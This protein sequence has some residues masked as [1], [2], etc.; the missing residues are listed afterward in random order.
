SLKKIIHPHIIKLK[1]VV[2]ENDTLYLIFEHMECNLYELMR[3]HYDKG[4]KGFPESTVRIV[5]YQVLDGLNY[6]HS[7]G[8]FHR[9]LK[10]ENILCSNLGVIKIGD[11]G[12]AR[13]I[14]SRPPYTDYVS[15]RWYRAPEVLLQ[16]SYYSF[17]ID[18]WAVGCI[19]AEMYTFRPLFPGSSQID[20][21]FKIC[22]I[23]GTPTQDEWPDGYLLAQKM[24]FRFPKYRRRPLD[25]V[26]A[27]ASL[28][29]LHLLTAMLEWN[30]NLRPSAKQALAHAYFT[31]SREMLPN[32][33]Q[34]RNT[35]HI[36][37]EQKR[38]VP[39]QNKGPP[40]PW[41]K[42]S[43][44]RGPGEN[45][46]V[47]LA[48]GT[49]NSRGTA[50]DKI[51]WL[52]R[53]RVTHTNKN[54]NNFIGQNFSDIQENRASIKQSPE[55]VPILVHHS[56]ANSGKTAGRRILIDGFHHPSLPMSGNSRLDWKGMNSIDTSDKAVQV[57]E[58]PKNRHSH[59]VKRDDGSLPRKQLFRPLNQ[60]IRPLEQQ[61]LGRLESQREASRT[62]PRLRPVSLPSLKL[63][64]TSALTGLRH[65]VGPLGQYDHP[66]GKQ[67]KKQ[68]QTSKHASMIF[69]LASHFSETSTTK[70]LSGIG[71]LPEESFPDE[72]ESCRYSPEKN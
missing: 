8:I 30:P 19:V 34:Y 70:S 56:S 57:P 12:L 67:T 66:K 1:E 22:T 49:V 29:A 50:N 17:P 25:S 55:S 7:L 39:F 58:T 42:I 46:S 16:A 37:D 47:N 18:I 43:D 53:T 20:Q 65:N 23:S 68:K 2:R 62:I 64:R 15:T 3:S 21:L 33:K 72:D 13:D 69:L 32:S 61:K 40:N 10:P 38:Y 48:N 24:N 54:N 71:D 11:F 41:Q 14:A 6:M 35:P 44:A 4:D 27:A 28:E 52:S 60:R 45:K 9:D 5:A 26:V 36:Q 63:P 51:D 59:C 31:G